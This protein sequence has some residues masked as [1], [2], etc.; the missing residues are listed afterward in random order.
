MKTKTAKSL[1]EE[2]LEQ[3]FN[4]TSVEDNIMGLTLE[5]LINNKKNIYFKYIKEKNYVEAALMFNNFQSTAREHFCWRCYKDEL[6]SRN[7]FSE[8]LAA[9][10]TLANTGSGFRRIL[11]DEEI[12]NMFEYS[13]SEFLMTQEEIKFFNN[14]PQKFNIYRGVICERLEEPYGFSWSLKKDIGV[15]F[16][17]KLHSDKDN[18][19]LS[20]Y[21]I[22]AHIEKSKVL[23]FFNERKEKEIVCRPDDIINPEVISLS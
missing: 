11:A 2:C 13:N 23:G 16:S 20:K 9:V 19:K 18:P 21:V 6:I 12:I 5:I 17:Q 4:P 15:Y 8:V 14:L 1:F 3:E 7:D 10:Y 22:L